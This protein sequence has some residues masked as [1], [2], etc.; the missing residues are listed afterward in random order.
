MPSSDSSLA[1]LAA[2][3][4]LRGRWAR[5]ALG[6]ALV[7]SALVLLARD[8]VAIERARSLPAWL[9]AA[10]LVGKLLSYGLRHLSGAIAVRAFSRD[11]PPLD[12]IGVAASVSLTGKL[13]PSAATS[14]GKALLVERLYGLARSDVVAA[15]GAALAL[16]LLITGLFGGAALLVLGQRTSVPP[17][18]WLL[19]LASLGAGA[20]PLLL[21]RPLRV[22]GRRVSF[23]ARVERGLAHL[24]T[25][26]WRLALVAVTEALRAAVAF[27]DAGLVLWG[28]VASPSALVVGGL[29]SALTLVVRSAPLPT[30]SLGTQEWSAALV[31][32]ALGVD[33][34][35]ALAAALVGSVLGLIASTLLGG[36]A[37]ARRD[38]SRARPP[39]R[40]SAP[41]P[42]D[43]PPS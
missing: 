13:L 36:L 4:P 37:L 43:T 39:A 6:I 22:V 21:G 26:P 15:L 18:L 32:S 23:L 40:G 35:V 30:G 17:S 24:A 41:P 34:E 7:V 31:A 3:P 33:L 1:T 12:F 8:P 20:A 10:A 5:A 42:G 14:V 19:V 2:R 28:L 11:V 29:T 16:R 27:V 38:A 9:L 25:Q